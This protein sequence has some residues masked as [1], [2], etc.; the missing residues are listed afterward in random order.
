MEKGVWVA[1]DAGGDLY[2]YN[3]KPVRDMEEEVWKLDHDP[4]DFDDLDC[5]EIHSGCFPNLFWEDDPF[6]ISFDVKDPN[7][8]SFF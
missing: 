1:R 8:V 3:A 5:F 2:I 6:F 7:A 4:C